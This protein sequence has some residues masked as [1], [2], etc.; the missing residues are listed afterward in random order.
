M[1]VSPMSRVRLH[2]PP[3]LVSHSNKIPTHD[4]IAYLNFGRTRREVHSWTNTWLRS[5]PP[6]FPFVMNRHL[7]GSVQD[8]HAQSL[9]GSFRFACAGESYRQPLFVA[10]QTHSDQWPLP[11]EPKSDIQGRY[12]TDPPAENQHAVPRHDPSRDFRS[13]RRPPTQ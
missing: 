8:S 11:I 10:A 1:I 5:S 12:G 13:H 3:P 2:R 6:I 9:S 7:N 4:S